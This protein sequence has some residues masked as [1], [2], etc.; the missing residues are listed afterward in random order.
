MVR[1]MQNV[2]VGVMQ[3]LIGAPFNTKIVISEYMK[4]PFE[5]IFHD[6]TVVMI[7]T[8]EVEVEKWENGIK[9]TPKTK[10]ET[11]FY[12]KENH[13]DIDPI[14]LDEVSGFRL[15]LEVF[16]STIIHESTMRL[17]R[18]KDDR[19]F[20]LKKDMIYR[21]GS[22][23]LC[24]IIVYSKDIPNVGVTISSQGGNFVL[25]HTENVS[26]TLLGRIEKDLFIRQGE[27]VTFCNVNGIFTK[28]REGP[29]EQT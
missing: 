16:Q 6:K 2:E 29:I 4:K 24:E 14:I 17:V 5:A 15:H 22:H 10:E 12:I 3:S 7:G 25:Q 20:D 27:N 26:F 18:L 11:L 28:V 23:P 19:K 1:S 21:I 9:Y 13:E 8:C